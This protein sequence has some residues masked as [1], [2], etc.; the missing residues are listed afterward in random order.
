LQSRFE[1]V[2]SKERVE[3]MRYTLM[4]KNIEVA[5]IEINESAVA[6]IDVG[7][8]HNLAHVPLG[9]QSMKGGIALDELNDWLKGRS[10]PASRAGIRNLY[11]RLG[12]ESTAHLILK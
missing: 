9:V 1:P 11:M 8:V 10:I 3:N 4:H 12:R 2:G 5:D 6:I 7:T